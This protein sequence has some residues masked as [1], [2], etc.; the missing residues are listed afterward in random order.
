MF[1]RMATNLTYALRV[2]VLVVYA[3][4]AFSPIY[5]SVS[6]GDDVPRRD[7]GP[8]SQTYSLGIVWV[9]VLL[10]SVLEDGTAHTTTSEEAFVAQQDP[11]LILIKKKRAVS[12]EQAP[13][14]PAVEIPPLSFESTATPRALSHEYEITRDPQHRETD[15]YSSLHA[16]LSPPQ[17]LS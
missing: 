15:G 14:P 8:L 16:G 2:A 17:Y 6:V 10:S 9:N 11:D 7:H 12:R 4:Y 3:C 1:T 13:V 5:L